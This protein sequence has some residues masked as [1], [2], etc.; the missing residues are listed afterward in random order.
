MT[1]FL[2]RD[3]GRMAGMI[4]GAVPEFDEV[5]NRIQE[6]ERAINASD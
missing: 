3:Y 2:R 4:V 1:E 6:F 5:I